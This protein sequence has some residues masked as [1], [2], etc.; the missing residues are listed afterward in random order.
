MSLKTGK[1][2][3]DETRRQFAVIN[4]IVQVSLTEKVIVK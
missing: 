1:E 4:R 2:I 3:K